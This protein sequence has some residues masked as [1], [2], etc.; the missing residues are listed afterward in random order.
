MKSIRLIAGLFSILLLLP[1]CG[2]DGRSGLG[3]AS[4]QLNFVSTWSSVTHP[5]DFPTSPHFSGLIGVTHNEQDSY[6][7]VNELASV[8]IESMAETGGKTALVSEIE[9]QIAAGSSY[10]VIS[11]GG[12]SVSPGEV[13][14]NFV[15]KPEFPLVTLVSMV[16]P[17]PDW[18]VGVAGINLVENGEWVQSKRVTLYVYDAG[19]D[20]GLT[21]TSA[22]ADSNPKQNI[23]RIETS[24]F[25]VDGAVKPVGEFVFTKL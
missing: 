12:I 14:F 20:D 22:D 3:E 23:K 1:S 21:Y 9:K 6:W 15:I 18:F 16:A 11:A 2:N 13:I 4:Y 24:P 10:S 19:T 7:G 25:L 8:G 17:S 5:V